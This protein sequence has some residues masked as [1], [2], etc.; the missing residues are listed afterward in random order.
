MQLPKICY[1]SYLQIV[2]SCYRQSLA[3]WGVP[4]L[5]THAAFQITGVRK[6]VRRQKFLHFDFE[7]ISMLTLNYNKFYRYLVLF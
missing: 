7:Q 3:L 6:S 2:K 4:F 1:L 5:T